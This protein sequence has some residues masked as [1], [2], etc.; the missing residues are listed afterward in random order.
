MY[1]ALISSTNQVTRNFSITH[2]NTGSW[3]L[4][5]TAHSATFLAT[6]AQTILSF[7]S[8][9]GGC[10]C[11]LI[12]G[13]TAEKDCLKSPPPPPPCGAINLIG[14]GDFEVNYS[15]PCVTAPGQSPRSCFFYLVHSLHLMRATPDGIYLISC[16]CHC[17]TH[18]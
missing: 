7:T 3:A 4:N 9:Q 15:Q 12:D 18:A 14:N 16:R 11:M 6:S 10:G 8:T 5:W 13:V 17:H 2:R 1:V